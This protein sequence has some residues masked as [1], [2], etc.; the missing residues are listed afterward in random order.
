PTDLA[1]PTDRS[2]LELGAETPRAA[3]NARATFAPE[4]RR[5]RVPP[6]WFDRHAARV[7]ETRLPK[8]QEARYAHAEVIGTDGYHLLE[9]LRRDPAAAWLWQVPAVEILRRGWLFPFYFQGHPVPWP[10]PAGLAPRP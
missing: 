9:A 3:L 1:V 4:W 6:E 2:R 5:P 10:P 8:G 7:E